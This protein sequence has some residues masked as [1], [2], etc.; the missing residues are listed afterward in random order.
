MKTRRDLIDRPDHAGTKR[1]QPAKGRS[2]SPAANREEVAAEV[3][4]LRRH[5][6]IRTTR[7]T[8]EIPNERCGF[9]AGP[10]GV[11]KTQSVRAN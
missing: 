7:L 3:G 5:G 9:C 8:S 1:Y 6:A 4:S 10:G 2:Q 11:S